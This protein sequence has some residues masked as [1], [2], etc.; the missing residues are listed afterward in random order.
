MHMFVPQAVQAAR[1]IQRAARRQVGLV[2][3]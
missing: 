3:Q 1:Q 2:G